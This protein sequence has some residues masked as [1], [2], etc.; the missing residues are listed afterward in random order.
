MCG[1]S[2]VLGASKLRGARLGQ[3]ALFADHVRTRRKTNAE[4]GRRLSPNPSALAC[5]LKSGVLR[6]T[7]ENLG[8]SPAQSVI[9][10]A[11][12]SGIALSPRSRPLS[13]NSRP[14]RHRPP[15]RSHQ[16]SRRARPARPPGDQ[17]A[18]TGVPASIPAPDRGAAAV[19]LQ[20]TRLD[21]NLKAC[22]RNYVG[23]AALPLLIQP[24]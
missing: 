10:E 7:Y 1:N 19:D 11:T 18:S 2:R 14:F 23:R 3:R 16:R 15:S 21:M 13:P 4:H 17:S 8:I 20:E 24:A 5:V 22:S 9:G 12:L 6:Q